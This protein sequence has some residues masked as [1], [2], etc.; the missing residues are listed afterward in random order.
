MKLNEHIIMQGC[1]RHKTYRDGYDYYTSG[2]VLSLAHNPILHQFQAEVDGS[3]VYDVVIGFNP[4]GEL[5]FTDCDCPAHHEYPGYCKHIVAVMFELL[6]CKAQFLPSSAK[7]RDVKGQVARD[8]LSLLDYQEPE[9]NQQLNLDITLHKLI[10]RF[11]LSMKIGLEKLYVLK[12]FGEFFG[13][14]ETLEPL[15]YGKQFTYDPSS[16]YFSPVDLPVIQL[17][18]ELYSLDNYLGRGSYGRTRLI[19]KKE[20]TLPQ[21]M[22]SRVLELLRERK[23]NLELN[24]R[25]LIDV[26]VITQDIALDFALANQE[27]D[28]ALTVLTKARMEPLDTD[29]EYV[30]FEGNV[31]KLS[32]KQARALRPVF[33]GLRHSR[34]NKIMLPREY[35]ERFVSVMLPAL[36]KVGDVKIDP[37]LEEDF[38]HHPLVAKLWLDGNAHSVGAKV[39]FSYGEYTI[40][41]FSPQQIDTGDK[42]LV[43]DIEG[44]RSLM[45]LLEQTGFTVRGDGLHLDDEDKIF[46]L[47]A[48]VTPKLQQMAEVFYSDRLGRTAVVSRPIPRGRVS[49]TAGNLLEVDF[50]LEGVVREELADVLLALKE[51][52]RYHR[53]KD[54]SLLALDQEKLAG[55][56]GMLD[57]LDLKRGELAKGTAKVPAYRALVVDDFLKTEAL[58]PFRRDRSFRDL[59]TSILEADDAEYP[60]PQELDSVLRDYQKRGYKWLKTLANWGMGGILADEMG[61]GKT[62]Q[63][64]TLLK[65]ELPLEGGPALVVAP[66]SLVYNWQAEVQRF[67][68]DLRVGV[69][70]GNREERLQLQ[71]S[72]KDFDIVVTSYALIRRDYED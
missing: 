13:A 20:V 4:A 27:D 52:R 9:P 16:H 63:V 24:N 32:A 39:E 43:R 47:F 5:R 11:A 67:A 38:Y 53:L 41:P 70:A 21:A 7:T 1:A 14:R 31:H 35:R 28:L 19:E 22:L 55:L 62:L 58:R 30:V 61:L 64:I 60:L 26:R 42:I 51:R 10:D 71:N 6:E 72:L 65:S 46:E 68:P 34:D 12:D 57:E 59:V 25:Y 2:A 37:G 69:L 15:Y 3:Y 36:K 18:Q 66:T 40:N 23:F 45:D 8:M 50:E 33:Y 49:M 56:A 17:V 54:G 44:E 48:E 29:M